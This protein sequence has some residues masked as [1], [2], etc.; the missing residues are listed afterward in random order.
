MHVE[1]LKFQYQIGLIWRQAAIFTNQ[2]QQ[3]AIMVLTD[4]MVMYMID[5]IRHPFTC[6]YSL[7]PDYCDRLWGLQHRISYNQVYIYQ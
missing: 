1:T 3:N 7:H 4:Y 2:A 6:I 5:Y